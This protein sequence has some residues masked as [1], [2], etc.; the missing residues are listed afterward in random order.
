MGWIRSRSRAWRTGV[1]IRQAAW[2]GSGREGRRGRGRE[3]AYGE[4]V[5]ADEEV[6]VATNGVE[7]EA[8]V[9]LG[10]VGDVEL[11]VV[12]EVEVGVGLRRRR[13]KEEEKDRKERSSARLRW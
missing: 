9:G 6:L 13:R 12:G 8:L 1:K 5:D 3:S 10:G 7:D 4:L 2:E 11:A